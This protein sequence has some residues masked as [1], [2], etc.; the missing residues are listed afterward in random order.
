LLVGQ[1]LAQISHYVAQ[2]GGG[3]VPVSILVEHFEGLLDILFL[4]WVLH[5]AAHHVKKLA[6]LNSAAS[7]GVNLVD[8]VLEFGFRWILAEGPHHSSQLLG[9]DRAIAVLVKQRERLLEFGDLLLVQLIGLRG[10]RNGGTIRGQRAH[11]AA[12]HSPAPPGL[13]D[14]AESSCQVSCA[15]APAGTN[16]IELC[17]ANE[18]GRLQL[19]KLSGTTTPLP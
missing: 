14:N 16:F 10:G 7:V 18:R 4:V 2:L 13:F 8:H 15:S 5:L 9:R 12:E 19:G 3:D 17:W 11:P 1:L 6:E